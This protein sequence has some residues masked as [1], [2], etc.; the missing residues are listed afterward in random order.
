MALACG[1]YNARSD[2]LRARS[3]YV[4]VMPTGRLRIMQISKSLARKIK[5]IETMKA[6]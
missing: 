1:W 6:D 5:S 3:D 2:W 4:A